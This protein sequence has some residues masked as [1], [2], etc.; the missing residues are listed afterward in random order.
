MTALL[1]TL[2]VIGYLAIVFEHQI[3]VNKTASALLVGILLWTSMAVFGTH[4]GDLPNHSHLN[5]ELSHH[6]SGIAEI[7][8]FI[9]GAMTIVEMIDSHQGLS[10]ITD[11]IGTRSKRKLLWI[12][13]LAAFGLSP[14]LDN[15]TTAI[16]MA[17]LVAKF[18]PDEKDRWIYGGMVIIAANA[19]GVWSPMG[20]IT[21]TMLWIGGQLTPLHMIAILFLPSLACLLVPLVVLTFTLKGQVK[22]F[23]TPAKEK[24]V[25]SAFTRTFIFFAGMGGLLSVPFF[26]TFTQLP[27]Y[28]GMLLALGLLWLVT[29]LF[30]LRKKNPLPGIQSVSSVISRID[31]PSVL[32]F[33]GILLA[34]AA[35]ESAGLLKSLSEGMT[36]VIGDQRII[37]LALGFLSAV[38]DNVPLV[39]GAMGMYDLK[40]FPHDSPTWEM[41]AYAAGT[42]G[43][44]LIVGS[45]AG[46]AIMGIQK[47]P[48][49]WYLKRVSGLALLGYLAGAGVYLLTR[50]FIHKFFFL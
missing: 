2:F 12:I 27:P 25:S 38:I 36:R 26:K 50:D 48:F 41:L 13:S 6:L 16:V 18:I 39:A 22:S 43:S 20:D 19:G 35:L 47:I 44:M 8:F 37:M 32:F 9:I 21:T 29:E 42:G 34:V 17:S 30:H 24:S 10:V 1:I 28:L 15:L 45:A 40:T 23:D 31:I 46:V 4:S 5:G 14:V 3:G 49:L 11:R 7:L 33:F